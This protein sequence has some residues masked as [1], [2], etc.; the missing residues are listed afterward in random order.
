M[1]NP[2]LTH[3]YCCPVHAPVSRSSMKNREK[4][5]KI[6][7]SRGLFWFPLLFIF[8][9]LL[10]FFLPSSFLFFPF[11]T[12]TRCSLLSSLLSSWVRIF[13]FTDFLNAGKMDAKKE[14]MDKNEAEWSR[15]AGPGVLTSPASRAA[16]FIWKACGDKTQGESYILHGHPEPFLVNIQYTRQGAEPY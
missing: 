1:T 12:P 13:F 6:Y 15:W 9:A 10:P 7:K 16:G 5:H 8:C 3:F 11:I 14:E 2:S 4:T